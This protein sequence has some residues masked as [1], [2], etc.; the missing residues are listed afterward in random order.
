MRKKLKSILL[1][2]DNK[3][4]NHYHQIIIKGMDITERIDI[5]LDGVE[6]LNMLKDKNAIPPDLIF[7]DINMPKINGWEFLEAYHQLSTT[8]KAKIV[9]IMLTTSDNPKDLKR[10]EQIDEVTGFNV[11]PLT[12]ELLTKILEK[13]FAA[14]DI[15]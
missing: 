11:K 8:Q 15:V 4:D 7:L 12:E 9:I 5:A 10:A 1:I 6:A 2:D 13:Y 14:N 3:A